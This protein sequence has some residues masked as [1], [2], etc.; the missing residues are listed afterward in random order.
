MDNVFFNNTDLSACRHNPNDATQKFC[1][2]FKLED[3]V[4]N[5]NEDYTSMSKEVVIVN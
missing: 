3:I 1:P 5:A 2:I 4:N